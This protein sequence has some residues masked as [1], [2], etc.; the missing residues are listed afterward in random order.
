[1][2]EKGKKKN[3]ICYVYVCLEY[4]EISFLFFYKELM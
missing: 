2:F 1:M 3:F 4:F